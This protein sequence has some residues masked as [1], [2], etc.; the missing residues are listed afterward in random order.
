MSTLGRLWS[1]FRELVRK[2]SGADWDRPSPPGPRRPRRPGPA[3]PPP[4]D[5]MVKPESQGEDSDA[6]DDSDDA[7]V[8]AA[9]A[10]AHQHLD[11]DD[12]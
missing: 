2:E 11:D 10:V 5:T 12:Q 8:M 9:A 4:V 1:R 7:A 3:I 6:K